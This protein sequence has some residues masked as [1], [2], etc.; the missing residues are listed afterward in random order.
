MNK[1]ML[2][3][4]LDDIV[5]EG[6]NKAY[7]AYVLR[8][9]YNKHLM[10]G[11]FFGVLFFM[12]LALSPYF[13]DKI[14]TNVDT[15]AYNTP[16]ELTPP[17]KE[18][19]AIIPPPPPPVEL[20]PPPAQIRFVEPKVQNDEDVK[21]EELPP[22]I[23]TLDTSSNIGTKTVLGAKTTLIV[24]VVPPPIHE[25]P[26]EKPEIEDNAI[27]DVVTVE[28][29]PSFPDGEAAL[30]K[31][32]SENIKYPDFARDNGIEGTAYLGFTV[33]KDGSITDIVVR[34]GVKGGKVCDEEAMRVVRNMPKWKPG[35][36]NGKNV[37]VSYNLPVKYKLQ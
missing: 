16:I 29:M 23:T 13:I 21:N 8:K 24:P 27:H 5:F 20:P 30:F 17:P 36:Q 2:K 15:E 22:P 19:A 34:R 31:Y 37:R 33:E 12:V 1:D 18:T 10:Q 4:N 9:L 7:G 28:Q 6:R 11:S 32:L 3:S 26:D 25:I 35:K 14:E